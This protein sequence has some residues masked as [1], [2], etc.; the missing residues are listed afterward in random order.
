MLAPRRTVWF[1]P[2]PTLGDG[3]LHPA[4]TR[5]RSSLRGSG[6]TEE[7]PRIA[8]ETYPG[9]TR[10]R[11]KRRNGTSRR[12]VSALSVGIY[13]WSRRSD[14]NRRPADYE[15]V[16][17]IFQAVSCRSRLRPSLEKTYKYVFF[18]FPCLRLSCVGLFYVVSMVVPTGRNKMPVRTTEPAMTDKRL[19]SLVCPEGQKFHDF[20]DPGRR[21]FFV[22]VYAAGLKVFFYRYRSPYPKG[23]VRLQRP[24]RTIKLGNYPEEIGLAGVKAA[25]AR[26]DGHGSGWGRSAG[27]AAGRPEGG[28]PAG[29]GGGSSGDGGRRGRG[30]LA[31]ILGAGPVIP[32]SFADL[33]RALPAPACVAD[34]PAAPG[35]RDGAGSDVLGVAG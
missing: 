22:R 10:L 13:D 3:T 16:R 26:I 1:G 6:T 9:L 15:S 32:G 2:S 18:C 31:A 14:L 20:R 35:G 12:A 28:E 5:R 17:T 7:T 11:S 4:P 8:R 21:N 30:Q 33:A 25:M 34:V 23:A 29:Q 24:I 27:G 19:R